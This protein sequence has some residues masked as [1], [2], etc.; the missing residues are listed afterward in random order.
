MENEKEHKEEGVSQ[1]KKTTLGKHTTPAPLEIT[2]QKKEGEEGAVSEIKPEII[3]PDSG[4]EES[5][6]KR[7]LNAP[8][9]SSPAEEILKTPSPSDAIKKEKSFLPSLRTYAGDVAQSVKRGKNSLSSMVIAEQRKRDG[10]SLK[11]A[12]QI[13]FSTNKKTLGLVAVAVILTALGGFFLVSL[14]FTSDTP[15]RSGEIPTASKDIIFIEE[16]KKISLEKKTGGEITQ[17]TSQE[18]KMASFPI[19]TV[20]H[21]YLVVRERAYEEGNIEGTLK[22]TRLT[23]AELASLL[24]MQPPSLFIRAVDPFFVFGIHSFVQN[25]P[26]LL[27][28][29]NDYGNTFS[30]MLE[31]EETL[32][33]DLSSLFSISQEKQRIFS[34]AFFKDSVIKNQDVRILLDAEGEV[35]L[36]YAFID[37]GVLLISTH[38]ITFDEITKRLKQSVAR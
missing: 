34:S 8:Q 19:N 12:P 14:F 5:D 32:I 3:T 31:W 13:S 17:K 2:P 24:R 28:K 11:I 23:F 18:I 38:E 6:N 7:N 20:E 25:N 27:F 33:E 4:R 16:A 35:V 21:I 37:R 22:E 36:L 10:V 15:K 9:L 29:V 30:G 1:E 26:F